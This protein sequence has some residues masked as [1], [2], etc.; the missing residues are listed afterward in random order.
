MVMRAAAGLPERYAE[1]VNRAAAT[2]AS[3]QQTSAVATGAIGEEAARAKPL[4]IR[5]GRSCSQGQT[6][7]G[8]DARAQAAANSSSRAARDIDR[9]L[10]E[11]QA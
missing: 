7:A 10:T 8:R 4:P 2:Q 9:A 1:V 6:T 3:I 11:L 5:T